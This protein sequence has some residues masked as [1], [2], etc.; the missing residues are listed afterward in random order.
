MFQQN[1]S[2]FFIFS[3]N[4]PQYLMKNKLITAGIDGKYDRFY[5]DE[6]KCPE[7]IELPFLHETRPTVGLS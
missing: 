7:R 1:L 5:F 4:W 6:Y 3:L 2:I